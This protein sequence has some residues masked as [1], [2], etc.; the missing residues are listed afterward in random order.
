MH[1]K[2]DLM[3]EPRRD[4]IKGTV[5]TA[6]AAALASTAPRVWAAGSDAP[7]KK[8]ILRHLGG[9]LP[10]FPLRPR[11]RRTRLETRR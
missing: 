2:E 9:N 7:E 10:A 4:F 11:Y 8:A 5:A 3:S 6:A 1:S